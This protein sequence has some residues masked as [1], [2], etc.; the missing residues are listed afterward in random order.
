MAPVHPIAWALDGPRPRH[1]MGGLMLAPTAGMAVVAASMSAGVQQVV[2]DWLGLAN[3]HP[4]PGAK[5]SGQSSTSSGCWS[6]VY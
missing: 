5:D 6:Y 2:G 1:G 3:E 4:P